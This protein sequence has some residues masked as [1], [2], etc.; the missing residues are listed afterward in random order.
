MSFRK[1]LRSNI[2]SE[3]FYQVYKS[4]ILSNKSINWSKC[5]GTDQRHYIFDVILETSPEEI[6]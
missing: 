4:S 6:L 1:N 3:Y 2:N 5:Y